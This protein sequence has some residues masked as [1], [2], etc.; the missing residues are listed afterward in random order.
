MGSRKNSLVLHVVRL[1]LAAL[2]VWGLTS[3]ARA[4]STT[5]S[6]YSKYEATTSGKAV[7]FVFAFDREAVL[8]LLERDVTHA[9]VDKTQVSKYRSYFSSFLFAHVVVKN[10]GKVCAHPA[11]LGK[12]FWDEATKRVVAVTRFECPDELANLTI[13][14][15]V[16][17]EMPLAHELVGDLQH[18]GELI[19]NFFYEDKLEA[20]FAL[21]SAK[22]NRSGAEPRKRGKFSHVAVPDQTRRYDSL[23]QAELNS[24]EPIGPA[25]DAHPE[26]TL[27]H[28][29]GQGVLHI[30]TGYDHVLFIVT[31]LFGVATWRRLALIVTSFTL[32]HSLTL[33]IATLGWLTFSPSIIEPLIAVTVLVVA[34]EMLFRPNTQASAILTF[35][36]GL[37]H[38]FGLSSIL[39]DL[40]LSGSEL[41]PALLG[42]NLGVEV[43]QLAIVAPLFPL[44]MW[45][46]KRPHPFTRARQ[47][48]CTS[49]AVL[50]VCWVVLR[51]Q[52]ALVG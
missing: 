2:T 27:W 32:A 13:R 15:D 49:V 52:E 34:V 21:K 39:R 50:A 42:F 18:E 51:V 9:E 25:V 30:F 40:G 5:Y 46:R 28:F 22:K 6:A 17:H 36:F 14:A 7:A 16:A 35:A 12:F 11:E 4:H 23:T 20:R 31:L 3:S 19:R 24:S 8:Q 10:N 37:I 41:V 45:L 47:V 29:I 38:G 33:A 43:G 26:Y 44:I 48:L 1:W